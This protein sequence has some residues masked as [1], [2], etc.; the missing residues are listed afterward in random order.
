MKALLVIII[1]ILGLAGVPAMAKVKI[2]AAENFYGG[3][4]AQ[5]AG[6]DAEVS[7]IL[8][9]PNQDPH[10]FT[11]NASTAREVADADIVIY[12]GL[13][14]DGW[15]EKLLGTPGKPDRIV[16]CVATLI[17]AKDGDNP[18]IWY[19][20]KTM[21]ALADKLASELASR[22][23]PKSDLFG[24][25]AAAFKTSTNS[26]Q[27]EIDFVKKEYPG[28]TVTATEPVFGYMADALGFKML[29]YEFQVA[30]MND[31]EPSAAQTALFQKSLTPKTVK[32]LF[33]NQQ[34]TDPTTE[35][36]K[37]LAIQSGVPIVGVTETQPANC[38]TYADWMLREI[39]AVEAALS[40]KPGL[41]D[42]PYERPEKD[43]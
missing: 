21:P 14:Y 34:V 18:H 29:N 8:S 13:G 12:N 23:T 42:M 11:T 26:V 40:N 1:A 30:V 31:T 24:K 17:G 32:I 6:P 38:K 27:D 43:Q 28:T 25:N 7:S 20:P 35:R 22:V 4:A 15:M 36:L 39:K 10:E 37:K 33:Y 3:V 41:R 9:N 2:V 5:I 19:S 16:I